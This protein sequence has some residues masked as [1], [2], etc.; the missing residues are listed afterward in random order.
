MVIAILAIDFFESLPMAIVAISFMVLWGGF[1]FP[2]LFKFLGRV[3]L[4]DHA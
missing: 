3:K 4:G 2:L 1:S